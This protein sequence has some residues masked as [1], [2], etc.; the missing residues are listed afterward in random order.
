MGEGERGA[1][2][3]RGGQ[4]GAQKTLLKSFHI[5]ITQ[6]QISRCFFRRQF[7]DDPALPPIETEPPEIFK[8]LLIDFS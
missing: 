8:L 7:H 4:R 2:G 5:I 6:E 3:G 1:E